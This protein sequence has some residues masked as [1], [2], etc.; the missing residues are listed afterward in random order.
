MSSHPCHDPYRGPTAY[1]IVTQSGGTIEVES[2]Q[3]QGTTFIIT[4]PQVQGAPQAL[5]AP[6]APVSLTC[7]KETVLVVDDEEI[8]RKVVRDVL[9]AAGYYVLEA[10]NGEKAQELCASHAGPIHL[11]LT[12]VVMPGINGRRLAEDLSVI[13]PGIKVLFMSGY[14][15]DMVCEFVVQ[16]GSTALLQKPFTADALTQAVRQ[17]LT[18]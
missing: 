2:E 7:G 11:L 3:G 16:E 18:A 6:P 8:L 17:L 14:I 13:R 10:C 4:L 15:D 1:G 5:D 9:L 12:D